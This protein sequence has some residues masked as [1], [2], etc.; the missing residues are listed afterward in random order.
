MKKITAVLGTTLLAVT[1]AGCASHRTPEEILAQARYELAEVEVNTQVAMNTLSIYSLEL[2]R[3]ERDY[4]ELRLCHHPGYSAVSK[5]YHASRE[6]WEKKF[7]AAR[8]APS[9]GSFGTYNTNQDLL[10]LEL[11]RIDELRTKW[12]KAAD[13]AYADSP[14]DPTFDIFGSDA[15]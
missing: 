12:L 5:D 2:A 7:K 13:D 14:V 3:M 6:V 9:E 8:N 15:P 11:R 10:A 1:V 4:L